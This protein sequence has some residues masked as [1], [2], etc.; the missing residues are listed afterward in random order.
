LK[1]ES[2][3]DLPLLEDSA[4]MREK[5]DD[6]IQ[7]AAF[8]R[9]VSE[10]LASKASHLTLEFLEEAIRGFKNSNLEQKNLCLEYMT[11]WLPNLSRIRTS[12]STHTDTHKTQRLNNII[13]KLITLTIDESVSD[14]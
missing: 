10:Q 7:N 11:P 3:N 2:G 4:E 8:I 14:P 12:T 6:P 5:L 1:V 9:R 13:D